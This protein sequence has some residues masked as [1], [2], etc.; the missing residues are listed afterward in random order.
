MKMLEMIGR[1]S[2]RN[3]KNILLYK[4]IL[5]LKINAYDWKIAQAI[6]GHDLGVLR[7]KTT[8]QQPPRLDHTIISVP[9]SILEYFGNIVVFGNVMF[10]DKTPIL[11]TISHP[12]RYITGEL[13]PDQTDSSLLMALLRMGHLYRRRGF[14]I[15]MC[16]LDNEFASVQPLMDKR[17]DGFPLAI[18]APGEHVHKIERTICTVKERTRAVVTVLLFAVL[19]LTLLVHA[20]MFYIMWLNFI[21]PRN[22]VSRRLSPSALILGRAADAAL[23]CKTSFGQYCQVYASTSN[24]VLISRT[25]GGINMGPTGNAHGTHLFL[26]ILTGR[27]FKG[28]QFTPLPA[29][30]EVIRAVKNLHPGSSV[31]RDTF[32]ILTGRRRR[33]LN[34]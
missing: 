21:P 32:K 29:P 8:F 22:G 6:H 13:L 11:V 15:L 19:P 18:C 16:H 23:H 4:M 2:D 25:V 27:Q 5:N 12:V 14:H 10:A 34:E 26:S 9:K 33:L 20:V 24:S 28:H 3:F 17:K 30:I 7:G 1:P 31:P